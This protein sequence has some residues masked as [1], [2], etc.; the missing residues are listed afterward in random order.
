[1]RELFDNAREGRTK[2]LES[3]HVAP[4]RLSARASGEICLRIEPRANAP[5]HGAI[6]HIAEARYVQGHG[7]TVAGK[8]WSSEKGFMVDA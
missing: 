1:V 4:E 3:V 7:K 8:I 6:A 2:A 5:V